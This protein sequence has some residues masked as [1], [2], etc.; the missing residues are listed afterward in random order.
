MS[1]NFSTSKAPRDVPQRVGAKTKACGFSGQSRSGASGQAAILFRASRATSSL[2][3][4]RSIRLK[5]E[6]KGGIAWLCASHPHAYGGF[7]QLQDRFSPTIALQVEDLRWTN[8]FDTNYPFDEE[9][10]LGEGARLIHTDGH[11][12]GHSVLFLEREQTLFAGDLLKFH[13]DPSGA[14]E[15]ISTHKGFN[16]RIPMSHAEIRRY[17]AVIESL[18]F[19]RIYTTFDRGPDGCRDLA[20]AMFEEQ[21]KGAPFFGP[22][23]KS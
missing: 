1:G 17:R 5:L 21:L 19:E 20:L 4:A 6:S 13:F 16:R 22:F 3:R 2:N 15:G 11:F 18:A 14:L 8:A 9:I 7:W 23:K 12:D 10:D